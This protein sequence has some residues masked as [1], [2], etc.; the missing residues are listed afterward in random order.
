MPLIETF[1][2]STSALWQS[3]PATT[4]RESILI[5]LFE[6]ISCQMA[7]QAHNLLRGYFFDPGMTLLTSK[8]SQLHANINSGGTRAVI[9]I[10]FCTG[11][12]LFTVNLYFCMRFTIF[13]SC[14]VLHAH[15]RIS[16]NNSSRIYRLLPQFFHIRQPLLF[17]LHG[18]GVLHHSLCA[19]TVIYPRPH[20]ALPSSHRHSV[21]V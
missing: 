10:F 21:H 20:P 17:L 11:I 4:I 15:I 9:A 16:C 3:P 1:C 8:G 7:V 2:P 19:A 13:S 12:Q 6:S 18:S 14:M 5:S